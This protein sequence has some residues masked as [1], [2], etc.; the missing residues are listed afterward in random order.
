M[1]RA[2]K[3]IVSAYQRDRVF[4]SSLYAN[5]SRELVTEFSGVLEPGDTPIVRATW[6]TYDTVFAAMSAPEIDGTAVKVRIKAQYAG[7]TR[8]RVDVT[9]P[10]GDVY[11]AWH[12]IRVQGAPYFTNNGWV[13]GPQHLEVV[14]LPLEPT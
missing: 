9:T 3:N 13:T 2:T 1:T 5:E 12:S 11:S 4:A 6:D 8:I 14:I 7:R 10:S